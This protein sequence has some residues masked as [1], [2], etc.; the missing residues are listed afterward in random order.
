M[1]L[2]TQEII[3]SL[4]PYYY[5]DYKTIQRGQQLF[6]ENR[7]RM[8]EFTG[9]RAL[10]QVNEAAGSFIVSL[11]MVAKN[12]LVYQCQCE[13]FEQRHLCK[14]VIGSFQAIKNYLATEG[15][16]KWQYR[17]SMVL[18][19]APKQASKSQRQRYI[20]LFGLQKESYY[21]T[22]RYTLHPFIL[23]ATNFPSLQFLQDAQDP[24]LLN[25]HLENDK[26]W[27]RWFETPYQALHPAACLN[28]PWEGISIA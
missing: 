5:I 2:I 21:T 1:P 3:E 23:K 26:T 25:Q 4:N 14:H 9:D 17:L 11:Q 27:R 19:D 20:V 16:N 18:E 24:E 13:D 6:R 15:E 10:C 28:L 12:K 7:I 22:T 8:I